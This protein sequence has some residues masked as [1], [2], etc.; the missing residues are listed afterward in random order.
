MAFIRSHHMPVADHFLASGTLS[1]QRS[2]STVDDC[3]TTGTAATIP[4]EVCEICYAYCANQ[5]ELWKHARGVHGADQRLACPESGCGRRFSVLAMSEAHAVHHRL[6]RDGRPLTCEFC[7]HLLGNLRA[8]CRHVAKMHP[9]ATAAMCG[10]CNLYLGDV[11]SLVDHVRRRHR[12]A[13]AE[14]T[15]AV[16][17]T[18]SAV[19]G[20]ARAINGDRRRDADA[21]AAVDNLVE[22]VSR[23]PSDA[24][25]SQKTHTTGGDRGTTG[26]LNGMAIRRRF[27]TVRVEACK[28]CRAYFVDRTELSKHERDEHGADQGTAPATATSSAAVQA[29][30]EGIQRVKQIRHQAVIQCDVCGK[31]YGNYH[32]MNKHRAVHGTVDADLRNPFVA[33]T[34]PKLH[35][36]SES[37]PY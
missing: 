28:T 17:K 21:R 2:G 1:A 18:T 33:R 5:T 32:N 16:E 26:S 10:V 25:S 7:G 11:P 15:A 6:A 29:D 4:G 23:R 34:F 13:M 8:F 22:P 30:P 31:R 24:N 27:S 35:N 37:H 19:R 14:T 12:S 36:S 3:G 9:D 20:I